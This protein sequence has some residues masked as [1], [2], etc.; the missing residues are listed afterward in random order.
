MFSCIS[1]HFASDYQEGLLLL[2][3]HHWQLYT[4]NRQMKQWA[5]TADTLVFPHISLNTVSQSRQ[6]YHFLGNPS[7][8]HIRAKD[9]IVSCPKQK[10]QGK[11]M[12][13]S[14]GEKGCTIKLWLVEETV[15]R[16]FTIY[17]VMQSITFTKRERTF[18]KVLPSH[19]CSHTK[20]Y[21]RIQKRANPQTTPA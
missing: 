15:L 16:K 5:L 17:R 13:K 12:H 3:Y 2:C 19:F 7:M 20:W 10:R 21:I 9:I 18:P 14:Q 11:Q 8:W 1:M 6:E 4:Q